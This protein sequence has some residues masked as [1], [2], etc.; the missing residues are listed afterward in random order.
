MTF[1]HSDTAH[2][3]HAL[4]V[5]VF[6][7]KVELRSWA[8]EEGGTRYEV[9]ERQCLLCTTYEAQGLVSAFGTWAWQAPMRVSTCGEWVGKVLRVFGKRS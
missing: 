9:V 7:L 2:Q 1:R 5:F 8:Q 6:P 3:R 4:V